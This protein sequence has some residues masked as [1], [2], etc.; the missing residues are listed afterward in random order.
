VQRTRAK[1]RA[2]FLGQLKRRLGL[3]W[4]HAP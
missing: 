3:G 2:A 4:K 1:R